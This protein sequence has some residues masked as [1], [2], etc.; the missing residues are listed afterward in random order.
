MIILVIYNF[1]NVQ[2]IYIGPKQCVTS[3]GSYIS[4]L[5]L[6]YHRSVCSP[7]IICLPSSISGNFAGAF[8]IGFRI[9]RSVCCCCCCAFFLSPM[10]LV[11]LVKCPL[12]W[13]QVPQSVSAPEISNL[14]SDSERGGDLASP[15]PSADLVSRAPWWEACTQVGTECSPQEAGG[16]L[17]GH[18][19]RLRVGAWNTYCWG[20][21]YSDI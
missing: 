18:L 21:N 11:I 12:R 7:F 14:L 1:W 13:A 17:V 4:F 15:S 19:L 5:W 10:L 2:P 16:N 8:L 6:N 9:D 20:K 3:K